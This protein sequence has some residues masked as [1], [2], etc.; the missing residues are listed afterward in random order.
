[1]AVTIHGWSWTKMALLIYVGRLNQIMSMDVPTVSPR[2]I[3][4]MWEALTST[5]WWCLLKVCEVM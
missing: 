3:T 4:I 5:N 2:N 1:M